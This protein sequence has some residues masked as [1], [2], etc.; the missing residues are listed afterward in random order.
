MYILLFFFEK[1]NRTKYILNMLKLQRAQHTAV[2]LYVF[3]FP[4]LSVLATHRLQTAKII[5]AKAT[6]GDYIKFSLK[7]LKLFNQK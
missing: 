3:R 2:T 4:M 7:A 1:I 5:T 6:L